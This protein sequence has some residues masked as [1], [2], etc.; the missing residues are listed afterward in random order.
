MG[1]CLERINEQTW[2]MVQTR[3]SSESFERTHRDLANV[4]QTRDFSKCSTPGMALR[5][6]LKDLALSVPGTPGMALTASS[7]SGS[8]TTGKGTKITALEVRHTEIWR[9]YP[10][11]KPKQKNKVSALKRHLALNFQPK[12]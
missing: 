10:K 11:P 7:T 8:S 2:K 12:L 3:S 6:A 4:F 1:H 5:K 9:T